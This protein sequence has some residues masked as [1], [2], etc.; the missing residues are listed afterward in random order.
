[1]TVQKIWPSSKSPL[2]EEAERMYKVSYYID[3]KFFRPTD[4]VDFGLDVPYLKEF[5]EI[6]FKKEWNKVRPHVPALWERM[7]GAQRAMFL[8]SYLWQGLEHVRGILRDLEPYVANVSSENAALDNV[9]R[10]LCQKFP[11]ELQQKLREGFG[12]EW[13]R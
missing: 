12:K 8:Y 1:V 11:K 13:S 3:S 10:I 4:I 9:T 2:K 6:R 5:G 7:N